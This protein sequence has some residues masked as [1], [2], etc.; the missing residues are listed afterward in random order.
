ME[1]VEGRP[2]D[3]RI[4]KEERVYDLL[5]QLNIDYQRIDHE[6]ANTMEICLE[7]EKTLKS[8]ICKN[9]FLVN[10][11]KSQYYL[12]MLKENKKFKTKMISKQINSSRLSF[13]SDEKML[14]YLDITPGSVSLLG[15]MND[16][17]F[18]VQL[19]MDKDLLQDE[20]LGCHP[21]INT[22]SLRI[23]MKDVFE[24]II[25]SLHHEPIFVEVYNE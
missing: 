14:E 8:T 6:E 13:G 7:I 20:Y 22:S 3:K 23:K 16:H 25:P 17:D 9:L 1:L 15:L 5:D 2:Q 12:L 4:D 24:K 11:N 10:S 21:C 19:L 18:K